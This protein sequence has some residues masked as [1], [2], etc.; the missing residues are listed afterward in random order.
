VLDSFEVIYQNVFYFSRPLLFRTDLPGEIVL[1]SWCFLGC[2]TI[3][4]WRVSKA[5]YMA[6]IVFCLTFGVW[7][8]LGYPQIFEV[9]SFVHFAFILNVITKIV[10]FSAL[11][12][13]LL[14]G[15]RQLL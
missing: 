12:L 3:R 10:A 1:F 2:T 11:L 13:L 8:V 7:L 14:Q 15:F 5:F 6:V 9:G 4:Y